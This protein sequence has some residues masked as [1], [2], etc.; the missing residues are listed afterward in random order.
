MPINREEIKRIRRGDCLTF[1]DF[2]KTYNVDTSH[3][4]VLAPD[5]SGDYRPGW[6]PNHDVI[7]GSN[8]YQC[9][10]LPYLDMLNDFMA[11]NISHEMTFVD[12]GCGKG[13][14][15]FYNIIKKAVYKG[16]EGWEADPEF[17]DI[18][19]KNLENMNI[20]YPRDKFVNFRNVDAK[21]PVASYQDC[22]YYLYYPF[23]KASFDIFMANNWHM[24]RKTKSYIVLLFEHDYNFQRFIGKDPIYDVNELKIYQTW[25]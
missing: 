2:D 13:K 20:E 21:T 10:P 8:G 5:N 3:P 16:Y 14:T 4:I 23:N 25:D 11:E 24:I 7:L 15:I 12:V 9:S 6:I 19:V 17:Y 1:E 22:V 18:A